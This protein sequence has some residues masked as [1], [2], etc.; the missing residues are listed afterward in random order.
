MKAVIAF[1]LCE[2]LQKAMEYGLL[3]KDRIGFQKE[4]NFSIKS[5]TGKKGGK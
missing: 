2:I 4:Q 5:S 1:L 3:L